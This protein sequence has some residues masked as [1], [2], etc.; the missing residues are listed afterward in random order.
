MLLAYSKTLSGEHVTP[1]AMT[2]FSKSFYEETRKHIDEIADLDEKILEQNNEL[3]ALTAGEV[4]T[5]T[6][7]TG[8]ADAN[9]VAII[10]AT[11]PHAIT[12]KLTYRQSL[13]L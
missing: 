2:E 7:I 5:N 1:T 11:R 13:I 4:D 6:R 8:K 12:L 10:S 3:K 9:V